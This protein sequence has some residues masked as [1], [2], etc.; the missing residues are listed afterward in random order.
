MKGVSLESLQGYALEHLTDGN[1]TP[2][3][4]AVAHY[5]SRTTVEHVFAA[6][7]LRPAAWI[8]NQRL[9]RIR[10]ALENPLLTAVP[11]GVLARRYGWRDRA[12][13]YRNF[14]R[15]FGLAPEEY[16]AKHRDP[17]AFEEYLDVV[18]WLGTRS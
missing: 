16:R 9:E 18:A 7:G 10:E 4:I 6:A 12:T 2:E 1:L 3:R 11:M 5:C 14:L 17:A 15:R 13:L 8:R